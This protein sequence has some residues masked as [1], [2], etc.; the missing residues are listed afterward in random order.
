MTQ[1]FYNAILLFLNEIKHHNM[2]RR[3]FITIAGTAA[4]AAPILG[5]AFAACSSERKK[6]VFEGHVF[7]ELPYAYDAL[8]PYIDAQTMELH[9]DKHHRGY[10]SKFTAAIEGTESASSPMEVIFSKISEF[11]AGVRNNGGGY[12][13]HRLFWENMSPEKTEMSDT[14]EKAISDSFGS[15]DQFKEEF[16]TAAKTRFGSGWAWLAIDAEGKLFVTSSPNQDNLLMDDVPKQGSPLLG[17]DVW[18]HAYYLHY[19]NRRADYVDNFW[20]I[21]NWEEVSKRFDNA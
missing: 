5:S 11:D 10:F 2:E 8:E 19:Q 4:I 3:N 9:Y 14:L 18:E 12:Y 16:G 17:L 15:V 21:V 13:N 7:P 20:N 1:N 6:K